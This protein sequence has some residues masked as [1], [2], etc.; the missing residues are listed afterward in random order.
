[1]SKIFR[2][3]KW[4]TLDEA[5]DHLELA[6]QESVSVVDLLRL[7]QDGHLTLSANF[8]NHAPANPGVLVAVNEAKM[9]LVPLIDSQFSDEQKALIEQYP[10]RGSRSEQHAWMLANPEISN[11]PNVLL[12]LQGDRITNDH[13]LEWEQRVVSIEGL[14]D[15]PAFGGAS[16]DVAHM[17]QS[18]VGGP[19]ITLVC[20]D[21][22]VVVS[23][24]EGRYARVL[25]RFSNESCS[26][27]RPYSDARNY[28]P[29]G[30][31][32]EDAPIV[33]RAESISAFLSSLVGEG[34]PKEEV[35][36]RERSGLLKLIAGL[37]ME[38]RIDLDSDKAATQM[39]AAGAPF[40][41]PSEQ[42]VRKHLKLIREEVLPGRRGS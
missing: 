32:P 2:L 20:L 11:N 35:G 3:K 10:R 16:L 9:L 14:W 6:L 7:A 23:P 25:E 22:T 33:V 8:V 4:L 41:G 42:T 26:S 18:L 24:D 38:A 1:M 15:L 36:S 29:S 28:F 27:D 17:L 30:G 21:G 19:E 12:A 5:A 34:A 31:L 39:A 40:G 37:A 13:V